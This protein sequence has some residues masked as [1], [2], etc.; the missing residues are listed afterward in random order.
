M[1]K[2]LAQGILVVSWNANSL[3]PKKFELIDFLNDNSPDVVLIQE[4]FLRPYTSI[5]FPNFKVYR[6]DRPNG[7]GGGT[8]VLVKGT[9]NHTLLPTPLLRACEATVVQLE[10]SDGPL[11]LASIYVPNRT[12]F[13][14][15]IH[16]LR[17]SI[18]TLKTT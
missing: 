4:T 13:E 17:Y 7:H 5:K 9:H 3:N 10:T 2:I 6:N 14:D 8:A 16:P 18:T 12:C 15:K 1:S 11:V